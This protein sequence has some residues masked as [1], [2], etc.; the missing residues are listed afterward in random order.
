MHIL[1][2]NQALIEETVTYVIME[3]ETVI[4]RLN[5]ESNQLSKAMIFDNYEQKVNL[6]QFNFTSKVTFPGPKSIG[7]NDTEN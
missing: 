2:S 3:S 1:D 6:L 4:T 7:L 5:Y